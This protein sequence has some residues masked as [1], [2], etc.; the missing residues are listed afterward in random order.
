MAAK[1]DKE[2]CTGCGICVD[3]CPLEAITIENEIAVI[4]D[5]C[6]ECG[7]C[8]NNCPNNAISL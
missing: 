3:A 1:V 8:E 5:D 7:V 2:M 4:S 6:S